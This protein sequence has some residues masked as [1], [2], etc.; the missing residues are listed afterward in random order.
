[1][2]IT[3]YLKTRIL[4]TF[5]LPMRIEILGNENRQTNIHIVALSRGPEVEIDLPGLE[6]DFGTIRVLEDVSKTV[7]LINKSKIPAI[8]HAFTREPNSWFVPK[9]KKG[10]INPNASLQIDIICHADDTRTYT[11][12]LHFMINESE[13]IDISLIARAGGDTIYD[14]SKLADIDFGT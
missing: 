4:D 6:L 10:Q 9:Q 13:S 12:K 14:L 1:M 11:D 5:R 2:Q 8:F 3:V 7:S